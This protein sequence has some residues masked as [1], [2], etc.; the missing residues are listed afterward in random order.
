MRQE[1]RG[2]DLAASIFD[3][4]AELAQLLL[5]DGALSVCFKVL[6]GASGK[7]SAQELTVRSMA[8]AGNRTLLL[9]HE[10]DCVD[11]TALCR[12]GPRDIR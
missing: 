7:G 1:L 4:L 3:Q 5:R 8:L 6:V 11:A 12:S 2:L 10:P 9:A